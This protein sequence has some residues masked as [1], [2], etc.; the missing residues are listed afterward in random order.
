MGIN[1]VKDG[2]I[3]INRSNL[4]RSIK[5]LDEGVENAIREGKS[6]CS[7]PEGTRRRSN[8]M[9]DASHLLSFKKGPFHMAK[10][11][12]LDLVPVTY[13]GIKRL[14]G[15][16]LARPGTIVMRI[17]PRIQREKCDK[18]SID[19]TIDIAY[20]QM[21]SMMT[22][23][24]DDIIYNTTRTR[25][26]WLYFFGYQAVLYFTLRWLCCLFCCGHHHHA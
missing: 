7:A 22:P 3:L 19:Q 15:G 1:C 20:S 6:I 2:F 10:K 23:V 9:D 4:E 8:S 5:Q 11:A 16:W 21:K 13:S 18:L 25:I 24:G 17:G 26:S 14:T 12:N